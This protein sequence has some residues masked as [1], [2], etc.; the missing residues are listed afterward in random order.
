MIAGCEVSILLGSI[1]GLAYK[2]L[3]VRST[4]STRKNSSLCLAT[5]EV[6]ITKSLS[7]ESLTPPKHGSF[8]KSMVAMRRLFDSSRVQ[9]PVV[10]CEDSPFTHLSR[11]HQQSY[12][13]IEVSYCHFCDHY[14]K[15][16]GKSIKPQYLTTI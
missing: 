9:I 1:L 16:N 5:I 14:C 3:M 6:T 7:L 10:S 15:H 11:L 12:C 2:Y 13:G 4:S 8:S